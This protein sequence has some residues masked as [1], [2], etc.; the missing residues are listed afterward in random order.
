MQETSKAIQRRIG[1][2]NFTTR[3]YVGNGID[4]GA[5]MDPLGDYRWLFPMMKSCRSW[6]KDDGDAQYLEG[7]EDSIYDFVN[8]SHCLEHMVDP[9]VALSNWIR[10][11]KRAGHMAILVPDEDLYEQGVF[12]STFNSDHKWTFTV[13][14]H[15]SWSPKSINVID[16]LSNFTEKIQIL[17]IE[18][19]DRTFLY[20]TRRFDQTMTY[21]G[22][23]AIEIIMRKI[24]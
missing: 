22:E 10:V 6:D 11:T 1:D 21:I 2:I 24:T 23:S 4:I 7:V 8:S 13:H 17:K 16:L 5:G 12:P 20:N 15:T 9:E 3:Y 14:K 19:L 18:L